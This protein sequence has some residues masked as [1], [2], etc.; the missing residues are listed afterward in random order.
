MF[1]L[2]LFVGI[3]LGVAGER[4]R[5]SGEVNSGAGLEQ[6]HHSVTPAYVCPM[7][8]DVVMHERGNC[9]VCGMDLVAR[10]S[11]E[12]EDAAAIRPVVSVSPG[13]V[14]SLGVRTSQVERK[15]LL[16]QIRTAGHV[17]KYQRGRTRTLRAR[18]NGTVTA[19]HVAQGDTVS[20]GDVLLEVDS[21]ERVDAQTAHLDLLKQADVAP[22]VLDRSRRLLRRLALS[23][24]EIR[25]LEDHG[26][27]AE[28]FLLRAPRNGRISVLSVEEGA[29]V[30]SNDVVIQLEEE[31]VAQVEV[32]VFRNQV[33]WI[34]AG[35][36]AQLRLANQPGKVWDGRVS[37]QGL[38]LR[39]RTR[40]YALRATF[41]MP[42]GIALPDMF[43]DV[44]IF[45]APVEDALAVPREALIRTGQGNRV[46]RALGDGR[47]QPV[48][49]LP[50]MESG[51]WVEILSG[52]EEG[53]RVVTS[54]QFLI[55]SES[56]LMAALQRMAGDSGN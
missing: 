51:E 3:V 12:M 24:E 39:P 5:S 36:R 2:V 34:K 48:D 54:A 28:R 13:I 47:F 27:V 10:K 56:N 18:V 55:D 42:E 44:V 20:A 16:R 11:G 7:H 25:R 19:R 31:G 43:A 38:D 26:E 9:P 37:V 52:V 29:S 23:S 41:P 8:P 35:D 50:G 14:N 40:T 1:S 21:R 4:F 53:D 22:D 45:G 6:V 30:S 17:L 49:V 15:T 32:D 33:A 46:I